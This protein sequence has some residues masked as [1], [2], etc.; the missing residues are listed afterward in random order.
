M[1]LYLFQSVSTVDDFQ[2]RII[3]VHDNMHGW[4]PSVE[5]V[6]EDNPL[7][8]DLQKR[9]V[10]IK[11]K[12]FITVGYNGR[13]AQIN[14]V[15]SVFYAIKAS[16]KLKIIEKRSNYGLFA[17]DKIADKVQ[18]HAAMLNMLIDRILEIV[19]DRNLKDIRD[20]NW[21]PLVR[22]VNQISGGVPDMLKKLMKRVG[23]IN[24]ITNKAHLVYNLG[25]LGIFGSVSGAVYTR[26]V[27]DDI[28]SEIEGKTIN[29]QVV[30]D[31][32]PQ[33]LL[34][35]SN[36][37]AN[38]G[39]YQAEYLLLTKKAVARGPFKTLV[40]RIRKGEC[41]V[42]GCEFMT[43]TRGNCWCALFVDP[44]FDENMKL[45]MYACIAVGANNFDFCQDTFV[46]LNK[47]LGTDF[48]PRKLYVEL[49]Q[50]EKT[51]F[52]KV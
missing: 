39:S 18:I 14:Q 21:T 26:E 50:S 47:A 1:F 5:Y 11:E 9:I 48:D 37:E 36:A 33:L 25:R 22:M 16:L 4:F 13:I 24:E 7:V 35:L 27:S 12:V 8:V 3:T 6:S 41:V 34:S 30:Q 32:K 15:L 46:M 20:G 52:S 43:D 19:V 42:R 51:N 40:S 2:V 45:P 31:R 28:K 10:N 29:P 17:G 49:M 44:V 38:L 23:Y